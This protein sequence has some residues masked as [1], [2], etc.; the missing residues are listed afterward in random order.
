M[1]LFTDAIKHIATS[2]DAHFMAITQPKSP[3]QGLP[4]RQLIT[5]RLS[6]RSDIE[7]EQYII[8][9]GI[10]VV[11]MCYFQIG[12]LIKPEIFQPE[13]VAASWII[14]AYFVYAVS[15][16]ITT[17][18]WPRRTLLRP[19]FAVVL[20]MTAGSSL[21]IVVGMSATPFVVLYLWAVIG[22]GFRFG[23][24]ML[25]IAAI[26]GFI[27]FSL[28]AW[29]SPFWRGHGIFSASILVMLAI[30]PV[31]VA[32]LLRKLNEALVDARQANKAK[33]DFLARMSH[34]IRT[35]LNG[36]IGLSDLLADAPLA[37]EQREV[38]DAIQSSAYILL[39]L[40]EDVLDI[41]SIETGSNVIA[42]IDFDLHRVVYDEVIIFRPLMRQKGVTLSARIAPQMPYLLH[43]DVRNLKQ[44]LN[45][46]FENVARHATGDNLVISIAP[47]TD[48]EVSVVLR[49]EIKCTG[50]AIQQLA[51]EI[52]PGAGS[53]YDSKFVSAGADSG[54][55][56]IITKR[57]VE[58]MQGQLGFSNNEKW[59][60]TLWLELP[61]ERQPQRIP[62]PAGSLEG[63]NL[64]LLASEQLA[65]ELDNQLLA[66]GVDVQPE[67]DPAC[68]LST[69]IGANMRDTPHRIAL[70]E[71]RQLDIPPEQ[72]ALALHAEPS[73]VPLSLILFDNDYAGIDP[74]PGYG[75]VLST[76]ADKALLFNALHAA[77]AEQNT[78]RSDRL[79][80]H[81]ETQ[82]QQSFN[83]LV[84]EDNEINRK[85]IKGIL[86]RVD[87]NA[88]MFEDGEQALSEL[89]QNWQ[90][91]DLVILDLNMP[92]KTGLEVL[93]GYDDV[94]GNARTP[95]IIL[96]ANA[97]QQ[98]RDE[99]A[100][101]GAD[102]YLAKPVNSKQLLDM[103]A[104][105]V[106]PG[107]HEQQGMLSLAE[108]IQ[109][110][111]LEGDKKLNE[112]RLEDLRELGS[113]P[114]FVQELVE[115]F[116]SDGRNLMQRLQA[117]IDDKDHDE[118]RDV[119]H[120]L[121]G[122]AGQLGA[123]RLVDSCCQIDTIKPEEMGSTA[124]QVFADRIKAS[125]DEACEALEEYV[126]RVE[127]GNDAAARD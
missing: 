1:H 4:L 54:A 35:P 60:D 29:L 93:Q 50:S 103:V 45:T 89:Q 78:L 125:F 66:W 115:G 67:V 95:V 80:A 49:C 62:E 48:T 25:F 12:A 84:A 117:A 24:T 7:P 124:S 73:I 33:T 87:H 94:A 63:M 101:A 127:S 113:S 51:R 119:L 86:G 42:S 65:Q 123:T 91:Y 22:N 30:L 38:A 99:C 59:N 77:S 111:Y 107:Q 18:F 31:Y 52:A 112:A 68:A 43:G 15:F 122:A 37:N 3:Q 114:D 28:V 64:L 21:L 92:G 6:D 10:A 40:V 118:L 106:V 97:T 57:L 85:V 14:G 23:N 105:L 109:P 82:V 32:V 61:F 69:L 90:A 72:F 98:A 16:F 47:V 19:M 126:L 2:P 74:I 20:D 13:L 70:I 56:L 102:A 104:G 76:L 75:C 121:K 5:S 8:R 79:L 17:L 88:Y 39:D 58:L 44:V 120:A 96:T 100:R 9:I 110:T 11:A 26:G 46:L 41:S 53:Q 34:E 108:A 55:E 36:I 71:R 83:I 81:E 116:A 27:S